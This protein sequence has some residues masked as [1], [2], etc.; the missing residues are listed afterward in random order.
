MDRSIFS[1]KVIGKLDGGGAPTGDRYS[2]LPV[3]SFHHQG[4]KLSNIGIES[5]LVNNCDSLITLVEA[6][7]ALDFPIKVKAF[8]RRG[9]AH[10]KEDDYS[11]VVEAFEIENLKTYAVQWHPEELYGSGS[12][13]DYIFNKD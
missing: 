12:I 1:H 9:M 5:K 6:F 4:L 8:T 7:N 11:C 13:L 2:S 10:P 3:N